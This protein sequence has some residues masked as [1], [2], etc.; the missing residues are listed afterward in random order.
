MDPSFPTGKTA[1]IG[2]PTARVVVASG[3]VT[4]EEG[5]CRAAVAVAEEID[6]Y[7]IVGAVNLEGEDVIA[8]IMYLG[9]SIR[10]SYSSL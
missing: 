4:A 3:E 8:G 10:L 5:I 2:A 7:F 1:R 6:E 9:K